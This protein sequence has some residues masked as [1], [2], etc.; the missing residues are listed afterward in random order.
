MVGKDRPR[1]VA[2]TR[3][4][5]EER[6]EA[7]EVGCPRVS[8]RG[9]LVRL[10]GPPL[11]AHVKAVAIPDA[12]VLARLV[13]TGLPIDASADGRGG[14][15]GQQGGFLS[16]LLGGAKN[17]LGNQGG[18][19]GLLNTGAQLA[20]VGYNLMQGMQP[21]EQLNAQDFYN[22]EYGQAIQGQQRAVQEPMCKSG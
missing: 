8:L 13:A 18:I 16:N 7:R 6:E 1:R 15:G 9:E 4:H 5:E 10:D 21:A 3:R 11:L 22:P 20:P 2:G 19:G 14:G 12:P 17:F